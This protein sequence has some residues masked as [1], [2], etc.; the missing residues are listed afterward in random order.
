MDAEE[1]EARILNKL[2]RH[3]KWGDSHT[4][5]ENLKKGFPSHVGKE[6]NKTADELIREG[7]L[8][9]KPTSY[10]LEISLNPDK[11]EEILR[12]IEK[13]FILF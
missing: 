7:L 8:L 1:I 5:F 12:R 2:A 10:E 6:V 9:Q 4:S 11:K 13:F 3:R